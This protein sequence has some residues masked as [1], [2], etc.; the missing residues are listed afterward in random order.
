MD[1]WDSC[2]SLPPGSLEGR[3]CFCGLDLATTY[4]TSAFIALFPAPD[5]TFDVL[6]RFWIPGDNALERERRDR[7]PYTMWAN[8]TDTGLSFTDGN[9]TDYDFV[10]KDIVEF[11][12]VYNVRQ[13]AMDRWNA[14]QLSIQLQGDGLD[15]VGYGQ[16]VASMSAPSKMLENL[17]ASGKIRHAGNPV[18]SWMAGNVTVKVDAAGNIRPVKPKA[19]SSERIDGIVSLIMALGI[20]MSHRPEEPSPDPGIMFL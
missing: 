9:V 2:N 4:D 10:R 3:E 17:I 8:D 18:L 20:Q 1:A 19:G 13:I 6:C 11:S 12:K 16:G 15:L 7:V 5:G 14:T